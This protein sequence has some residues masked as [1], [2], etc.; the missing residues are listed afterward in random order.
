MDVKYP[1]N[2]ISFIQD[3]E[4]R[5]EHVT[6]EMTMTLAALGGSEKQLRKGFVWVLKYT[7]DASLGHLLGKLRDMGFLFMDEPGGW[8]P[9]AVFDVLREKGLVHGKFR[10]VTWVRPGAWRVSTR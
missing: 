8:P 5:A 10:A 2:Y 9:S 1:D 4:L 3:G 6:S 7:D